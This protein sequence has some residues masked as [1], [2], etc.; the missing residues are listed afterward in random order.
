M[1]GRARP[2]VAKMKLLRVTGGRRRFCRVTE[3]VVICKYISR[4]FINVFKSKKF[5][6]IK[7]DIIK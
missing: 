5:N 6:I 2:F 4:E 7:K 1:M 3:R